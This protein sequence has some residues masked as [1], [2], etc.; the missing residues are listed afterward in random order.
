MEDLSKEIIRKKSSG[1]IKE[2][3]TYEKM[4][5]RRESSFENNTNELEEDKLKQTY[6]P[7]Y[8]KPKL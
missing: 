8:S 1:S 2:K 4:I 3:S 7:K 6:L 5:L